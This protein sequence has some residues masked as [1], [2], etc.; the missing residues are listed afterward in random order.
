MV[1]VGDGPTRILEGAQV[2]IAMPPVAAQVRPLHQGQP[3]LATRDAARGEHRHL[4]SHG[5][6]EQMVG[7][8]GG[9]DA[10][11]AVARFEH[12]DVQAAC[13]RQ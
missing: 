7:L 2:S 3:F 12:L 11:T 5:I 13:F 1:G 6:D 10:L 4:R 8:A 9:M